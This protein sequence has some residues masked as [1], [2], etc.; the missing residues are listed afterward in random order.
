MP[1]KKRKR[2]KNNKKRSKKI[3]NKFCSKKLPQ[4]KVR[5]LKRHLEFKTRKK[6]N[7]I[8]ILET[9]KIKKLMQKL[10][11]KRLNKT[12]RMIMRFHFKQ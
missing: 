11:N 3:N 12:K 2:K 8:R 4:L 10:N 1:S 6:I 7:S 5:K 9:R